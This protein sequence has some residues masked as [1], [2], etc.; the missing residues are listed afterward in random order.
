MWAIQH[1]LTTLDEDIVIGYSKRGWFV[2]AV[3]AGLARAGIPVR[4]HFVRDQ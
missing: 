4:A 3:P 2:N 1:V